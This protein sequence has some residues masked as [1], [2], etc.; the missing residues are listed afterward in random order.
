MFSADGRLVDKKERWGMKMRPL[1][2]IDGVVG[3][4]G[5]DLPERVSISLYLYAYMLDLES[6]L[7]YWEL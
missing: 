1:E 5:Y 6:Y 3:N 4:K 2:R 7:P